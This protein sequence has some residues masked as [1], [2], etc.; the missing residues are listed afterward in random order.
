MQQPKR[1]HQIRRGQCVNDRVSDQMEYKIKCCGVV[2]FRQ[3]CF[4]AKQ[5]VSLPIRFSS[6]R[7]PYW[8]SIHILYAP[9]YPIIIILLFFIIFRFRLHFLLFA[10][11]SFILRLSVFCFVFV[12]VI[13]FFCLQ[14]YLKTKT[15]N[16]IIRHFDIRI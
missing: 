4:F 13:C 6:H 2:Q 9:P 5:C 14:L 7:F 16:K 3:V 10:S 11:S 8:F 12:V 15:I 1:E